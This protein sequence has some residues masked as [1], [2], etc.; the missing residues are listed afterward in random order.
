MARVKVLLLAVVAL[1]LTSWAMAASG[2]AP[3]AAA[4]QAEAQLAQVEKGVRAAAEL[5]EAHQRAVA[6]EITHDTALVAALA[7][8]SGKEG[9]TADD[10][11]ALKAALEQALAN[12]PEADRSWA[13]AA[14]ATDKG[15]VAILPGHDPL[16]AASFA[17]LDEAAKAGG[18]GK[19]AEVAG[20]KVQV[21]AAPVRAVKADKVEQLGTLAIAYTR[22]GS[23][24]AKLAE[25]FPGL[26]LVSGGKVLASSD[27]AHGADAARL[28]EPG[29]KALVTG[30][31]ASFLVKLPT[32]AAT[33][34]AA[35]AFK[36]PGAENVLAVATADL[37]GVAEATAAGQK[38]ALIAGLAIL[39]LGVAVSLTLG[40]APASAPVQ[41]AQP[42]PAPQAEA[43]VQAEAE[44]EP[45]PEPE[46]VLQG[47][48][49]GTETATPP[50]MPAAPP[51]EPVAVPPAA[52]FDDKPLV[53]SPPP[54]PPQQNIELPPPP[55]PAIDAVPGFDELFGP[56]SKPAAPAPVETRASMP[57][58][59][60]VPLPASAP[61][62]SLMA[63]GAD[64]E[65]TGLMSRDILRDLAAQSAAPPPP[66]PEQPVYQ[67]EERT[68]VAAIPPELLRA[69]ARAAP[70]P[71]PASPEEQHFQ[72]IFREFVQTRER[73][74]E[75][76]ENLT[77][78]KFAAKLRK[79]KEQLV[80]KYACKSV[81][82]QVY[83]KE[84][85]AALKATPVKEA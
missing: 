75:P 27:K 66:A 34:V 84:G 25:Q 81:R 82:F 5:T 48:I 70:A 2:G 28:T 23:G 40:G 22:D 39:V 45:S 26:T 65:R 63:A 10:A 13:A 50:R 12:L 44:P 49:E 83:V 54:P 38:T 53:F 29:A 37:T 4:Q 51:P 31:P 56:S 20:K 16:T 33:L 46:A 43:P 32:P 24:L 68:A 61:A 6:S 35:R 60:V 64:T 14:M 15:A 11:P 67:Q 30:Q 3:A 73:C 69:V 85:K 7:D 59:P 52:A 72:E 1:G 76:P 41:S 18:A 17:W 78:E 19:L 71:A 36:L 8:A 9:P 47:S 77:F 42:Q 80:Q 57:A 58:A 55:A 79:N 62:P 21:F 74:G